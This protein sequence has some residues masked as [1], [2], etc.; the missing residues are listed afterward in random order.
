[1]IGFKRIKS[2]FFKNR[3]KKSLPLKENKDFDNKISIAYQDLE[4]Y[5]KNSDY[6]IETF[7]ETIY[8]DNSVQFYYLTKEQM[9]AL[10]NILFLYEQ[11]IFSEKIADN[12]S[13]SFIKNNLL[14]HAFSECLEKNALIKEVPLTDNQLDQMKKAILEKK[15]SSS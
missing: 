9:M 7:I 3:C 10:F 11:K 13:R 6:T 8:Y 1:M 14:S 4:K 12:E 2:W 15:S 5:L